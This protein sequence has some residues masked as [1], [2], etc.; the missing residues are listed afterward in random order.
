M[1]CAKVSPPSSAPEKPTIP[2]TFAQVAA[3]LI[4]EFINNETKKEPVEA[5]AEAKVE[6]VSAASEKPL[7]AKELKDLLAQSKN[8]A[9]NDEDC[10]MCG[11]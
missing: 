8:A 5:V 3:T 6:A 9:E 10:L 1:S 2:A 4:W 11:S 7:T